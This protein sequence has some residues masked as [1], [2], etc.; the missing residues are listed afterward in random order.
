MF[1][2]T[3]IN[4]LVVKKSIVLIVALF[5][6]VTCVGQRLNLSNVAYIELPGKMIRLDT[7]KVSEY[8]NR[9]FSKRPDLQRQFKRFK[10]ETY[11][12]EN[13]LIQISAIKLQVADLNRAN[14]LRM[15]LTHIGPTTLES[16]D[17]KQLVISF[18]NYQGVMCY[19]YFYFN[20][21]A[22]IQAAG[23]VQFEPADRDKAKSILHDIIKRL[24]FNQQ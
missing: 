23:I 17:G 11:K 19:R 2:T 3:Y 5:F 8:S 20:N 1:I 12:I 13:V 16:I 22:S 10:D 4:Y 21:S 6:S 7:Q 14:Q 24:K 18:D 9:R 15:Q